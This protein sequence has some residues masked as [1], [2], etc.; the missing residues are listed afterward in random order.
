[1][2]T[3]RAE[4]RLSLRADNADQ[5]LTALAMNT[6][7]IAQD[8]LDVLAKTNTQLKRAAQLLESIELSCT[9]W[10][11]IGYPMT[12]NG[13]KFTAAQILGRSDAASSLDRLKVL[14][15]QLQ[16]IPKELENRIN[17]DFKYGYYISIQERDITALRRDEQLSLENVDF[18][19]LPQVSVE[20]KQKLVA[21]QPATIAAAARISG[22]RPATLIT[23]LKYVKRKQREDREQ[24][25]AQQLRQW[26]EEQIRTYRSQ[27]VAPE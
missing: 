26:K 3:S 16:E 19:Q 8:R 27:S 2:F 13:K 6:G 4:Y 10:A 23:L 5:R 24:L 7:C 25:E 20:E 12:Q 18:A 11:R 17:S 21:F 22:I 9:E 15:P 1:M 14:F